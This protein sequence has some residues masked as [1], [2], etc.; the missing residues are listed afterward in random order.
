[1]RKSGFVNWRRQN[2]NN[3]NLEKIGR[4]VE[5]LLGTLTVESKRRVFGTISRNSSCLLVGGIF[6]FPAFLVQFSFVLSALMQ[7]KS[8]WAF[9][10]K[11]FIPVTNTCAY[12][13]RLLAMVDAFFQL[14]VRNKWWTCEANPQAKV[15]DP[16]CCRIE[17]TDIEQKDQLKQ[18]NF[19]H[20]FTDRFVSQWTTLFL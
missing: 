16:F 10:K 15:N 9:S 1:M 4:D 20:S 17:G 19:F 5:C 18:L 12:L 14:Y 11:L 3:L 6:S 13:F 8:T 7:R 2:N